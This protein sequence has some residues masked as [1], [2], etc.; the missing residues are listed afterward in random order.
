MTTTETGIVSKEQQTHFKKAMK[1]LVGINVVS[2]AFSAFNEVVIGH[3]A[4][5]FTQGTMELTD[6][7]M[8][9]GLGISHRSDVKGN[10]V[11]ASRQRKALYSLHIGTA[12]LGIAEGVR[13]MSKNAEPS[14]GNLAVSGVVGVLNAH[15]IRHKRKHMN[16]TAHTTE[17]NLAMA[18]QDPIEVV[19]DEINKIPSAEVIHRLN[20]NGTTA[21]AVTN[22]AEA[23]GGVVG[24]SMQFAWERGAAVAAI[25][26]S[27]AV[28]GIMA[29]QI[30]IER[31][32]LNE[33][34]M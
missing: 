8:A 21:I 33:Q 31:T 7:A 30:R 12:A 28:I 4:L 22:I 10:H 20:E 5:G 11:R 25:T 27:V 6:T 32:V 18:Y 34:L 19:Q 24:A 16:K 29:N 3:S 26:S 14:M 2:F 17:P 13:L 1:K 15:Y 23:A 9:A